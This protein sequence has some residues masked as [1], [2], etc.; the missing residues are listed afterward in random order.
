MIKGVAENIVE[1]ENILNSIRRRDKISF[2]TGFFLFVIV[3]AVVG[4]V[5]SKSFMAV[6]KKLE[7]YEVAFDKSKA[8]AEILQAT[9][10]KQN[11]QI[12]LAQEK[13]I[14]QSEALALAVKDINQSQLSMVHS[15]ALDQR[16]ELDK[17]NARV[18]CIIKNENARLCVNK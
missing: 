9:I 16:N 17:L 15:M 2:Y 8:A 6:Q 3:I 13:L 18:S 10:E 11:Q 1:I 14:L 5:I 12:K 7:T 4:F